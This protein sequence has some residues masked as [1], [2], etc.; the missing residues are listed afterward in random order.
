MPAWLDKPQ[1]PAY[2]W[3][4]R[5]DFRQNFNSPQMQEL[6]QFLLDTVAEQTQFMVARAQGAMDKILKNTPDGT[7]R[8]ISSPSSR[9]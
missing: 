9:A 4:S 8:D 2:P 7:E 1:I 3:T 6:R 5:E